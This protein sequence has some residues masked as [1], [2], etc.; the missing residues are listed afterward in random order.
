MKYIFSTSSDIV[1]LR[2]TI[3]LYTYDTN[4]FDTFKEFLN[5]SSLA[6]S[7]SYELNDSEMR[8]LRPYFDKLGGK[9]EHG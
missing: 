5:L 2:Y 8:L 6:K 4:D 7:I 9:Y 3:H 1:V